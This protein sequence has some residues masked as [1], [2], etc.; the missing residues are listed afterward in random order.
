M[1]NDAITCS[2][3]LAAVTASAIAC[4]L[5]MIILHHRKKIISGGIR[6]FLYNLVSADMAYSM[7]IFAMTVKLLHQNNTE[8]YTNASSITKAKIRCLCFSLTHIQL[9]TQI[10]IAVERFVASAYP[11]VYRNSSMKKNR[12][13][14]TVGIWLFSLSFGASVTFPSILYGYSRV[15]PIVCG[16]MYFISLILVATMY[17]LTTLQ[18]IKGNRRVIENSNQNNPEGSRNRRQRAKHQEH[19]TMIY[20]LAIVTTYFILNTP[21]TVY[22]FLSDTQDTSIPLF[23]RPCATKNGLFANVALGLAALNRFFDPLL[24]FYLKYHLSKNNTA[25]VEVNEGEP[26]GT[27]NTTF[28]DD[29]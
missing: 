9:L 14:V 11:I 15:I 23:A 22:T 1:A 12:K 7:V 27:G 18:V 5:V 3:P 6:Y 19:S 16:C 29:N 26:G 20:S 4:N 24:Y 21:L 25:Q 10:A 17:G 8:E 13:I 2:S 28:I